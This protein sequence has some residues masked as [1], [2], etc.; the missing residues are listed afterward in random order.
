MKF[1]HKWLN[2][3]YYKHNIGLYKCE[4]CGVT[5]NELLNNYKIPGRLSDLYKK[6]SNGKNIKVLF[7]CLSDDELDIKEIVE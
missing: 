1:A 6:A 2:K 3:G 5:F 7:Q 4:K